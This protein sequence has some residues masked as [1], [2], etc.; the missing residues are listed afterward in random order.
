MGCGSKAGGSPLLG[1]GYL[2]AFFQ[3]ERGRL[4]DYGVLGATQIKE[5]FWSVS[6][7]QSRLLCTEH[8]GHRPAQC[9]AQDLFLTYGNV[10]SHDQVTAKLLVLETH[11]RA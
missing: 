3:S 1:G 11:S 8:T 4:L 6:M 9:P 2:K 5:R 10:V 7:W